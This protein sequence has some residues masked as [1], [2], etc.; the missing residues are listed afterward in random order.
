MEAFLGSIGWSL[1]AATATGNC[2]VVVLIAKNRRLH[3]SANWFVL[4]LA[5]AD[6]VV[7]VIVFP[8]GYICNKLMA[9]NREIEMAL[10]WFA[11]HASVTNLCALTRDR[12]VA[13]VYPFKYITSITNRRPD[14]VIMIAWLTPF[15]ISL[16]LFVGMYITTS[17]TARK[18]LRL[19]GVSV[20]DLIS[21]MLL[22]YAV[23][24]ILKVARA[25]SH[26]STAIELQLQSGH[27]SIAEGE[28]VAIRRHCHSS[29]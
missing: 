18:V 15:I 27:S 22:L 24:R 8:S 21:C 9:C 13:I 19:T 11:I 4:S 14:K 23:A 12:Y 2:F 25:Q 17:E 29:I 28:N 16:A 20:F 3:S 10:F 1:S 7:A 6:F 5:V 26:R